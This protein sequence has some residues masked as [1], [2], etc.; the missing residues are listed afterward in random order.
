MQMMTQAARLPVPAA[1]HGRRAVLLLACAGLA[2][3]MNTQ[4]LVFSAADQ[5]AIGEAQTYLNGLHRFTASFTQSGADGFAEGYVWLD[6]PGRLRVDYVRPRPKALIV[7]HGRL[8]LADHLTGAATRMPVANTP[9]DMLLADHIDLAGPIQVTSV[10]QQPGALQI[11]LVKQAAPRQ[12]MLTL[13]FSTTPM[14]L[15]GVVVQDQSGRTNALTLT[16]LQQPASIDPSR[17]TYVPPIPT[18]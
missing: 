10:Q 16:N 8:L 12:G 11:S 7:N 17:F 14:M 18:D 3:C 5:A 2:A 13:Q 9:L 4:K 1:R 6:R 15:R